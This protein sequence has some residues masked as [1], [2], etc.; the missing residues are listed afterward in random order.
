VKLAIVMVKAGVD[1]DEAAARLERA[2]GVV[3]AVVGD[4]P[5]VVPVAPAP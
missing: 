4:P 3:R 1:K 2:G 5:P